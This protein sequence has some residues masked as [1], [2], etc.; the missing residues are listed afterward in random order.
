M[1]EALVGVGNEWLEEYME[2]CSHEIYMV[3]LSTQFEGVPFS[4][5]A[6]VVYEA[7]DSILFGLELT[8]A[9]G[10]SRVLLNPGTFRIPDVAAY[11]IKGFVI[12]SDQATAN[13]LTLVREQSSLDGSGS[14][15]AV[16]AGADIDLDVPSFADSIRKSRSPSQRKK[17]GI[18]RLAGGL[19]RYK[20]SCAPLGKRGSGIGR[21]RAGS[22]LSEDNSV[23]RSSPLSVAA[24]RERGGSDAGSAASSPSAAP[25]PMPMPASVAAPR[26]VLSSSRRRAAGDS[27]RRI[28]AGSGRS[29]LE[30]IARASDSDATAKAV[31]LAALSDGG[32]GSSSS[33]G[34]AAGGGSGG[35]DAAVVSGGGG[36]GDADEER[37]LDRDRDRVSGSSASSASSAEGSADGHGHAA[38]AHESKRADGSRPL[39]ATARIV[40]THDDSSMRR[41]KKLRASVIESRTKL[42]RRVHMVDDFVAMQDVMLHSVEDVPGLEEHILLCGSVANLYYFIL[43]LRDIRQEAQP[44]VILHD[45]PLNSSVWE[46]IRVFP[47]VFIVLGSPL[48]HND[49]LRAGAHTAARAVILARSY[50]PSSGDE[51][52]G[53]R[54]ATRDTLVDADTVFSFQGIK[55]LN[56]AVQVVA[57]VVNHSNTSYLDPSDRGLASSDDS[58]YYTAPSFASGSVYTSSVLDI[59]M[60]QAFYNPQVLT[61]IR[62]IVAGGADPNDTFAW[63]RAVASE[64]GVVVDSSVYQISVPEDFLASDRTWMD[65]FRFLTL[66]G[67]VPL[68]LYRGVWKVV[69]D[70]VKSNRMPFVYTNPSP[71][72]RLSKCDRIFVL[73]QTPP[74]EVEGLA[75]CAVPIGESKWLSVPSS[76]PALL[77]TPMARSK[78]SPLRRRR[79]PASS[80]G[81]SEKQSV[82]ASACAAAVA[83][84][85]SPAV[86]PAAS[87]SSSTLRLLV[88][89]SRRGRKLKNSAPSAASKLCKQAAMLESPATTSSTPFK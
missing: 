89:G 61:L 28:V 65:L 27:S 19:A 15:V 66:R 67:V 10:G 87:C 3:P 72:T 73:S 54:G 75:D 82:A 36:G 39:T 31:E 6:M 30:P 60:A 35:G 88:R 18:A 47:N 50:G 25:M 29:L 69:G 16:A 11:S 85:A 52:G 17:V 9:A 40:R 83:S 43:P 22:T 78:S 33:S 46:K 48:A 49:L 84:P 45:K 55:A 7:L 70:G 51:S 34:R 21:R 2:G 58:Y 86:P 44:I 12:A 56:P 81:S 63:N 4:E 59:V 71:A 68:G 38:H 76:R 41:R 23:G 5:A 24:S 1:E 79:A 57:E 14:S 42:R 74:G 80:G 77:R 13:M 32:I 8:V 53:S 64:L 26:M 20:L 62:L 37:K